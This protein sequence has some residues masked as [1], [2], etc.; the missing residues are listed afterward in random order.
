MQVSDWS[1]QNKPFDDYVDDLI[2]F[3][4]GWLASTSDGSLFHVDGHDDHRV[5]CVIKGRIVAVIPELGVGVVEKNSG[6]VRF[7][8]S[9]DALAMDDAMSVLRAQWMV[10]VFRAGFV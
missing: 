5:L 6:C 9:A 10:A 1:V 2:E 8:T 7:W 4:S 3:G